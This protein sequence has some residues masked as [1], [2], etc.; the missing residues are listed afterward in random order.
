MSKAVVAITPWELP[1]LSKY[2]S[3]SKIK[4]IPNGMSSIFFNKVKNNNF[5]KKIKSKKNL[6]LF[7]GRL[8]VTK[9]PDKFVLAAKEILK[10]S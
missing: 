7:F 2:V 8:N 10:E 4:V 1:I 9:G 3:R 5:R 6:I